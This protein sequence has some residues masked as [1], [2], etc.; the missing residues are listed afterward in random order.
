MRNHPAHLQSVRPVFP[1]FLTTKLLRMKTY[2]IQAEILTVR[3]PDSEVDVYVDIYEMKADSPE[4]ALEF[5]RE[6]KNQRGDWG[7]SGVHQA[8][9][10]EC[11]DEE[12]STV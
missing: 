6:L 5:L 1:F 4:Q 10:L 8:Q 3:M 7:A 9:V 2:Y 11:L 12:P